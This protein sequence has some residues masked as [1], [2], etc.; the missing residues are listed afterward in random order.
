MGNKNCL[1]VFRNK[2]ILLL[3]HLGQLTGVV[4]GDNDIMATNKFLVDVELRN[5]RPFAVFLNA[6]S[7]LGVVKDI[8]GSKLFRVNALVSQDL[9]GVTGETAH[10]LLRSSLHKQ[11]NGGGGNCLVD[12][13]LD[14][15][16]K[17]TDGAK[18]VKGTGSS[19]NAGRLI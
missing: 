13:R 4:H 7:K 10:G 17:Q 19:R 14:F 15:V 2:N 1:V 18:S 12:G 16:R 6:L 9:D 11:D 8:V 3:K 5:S